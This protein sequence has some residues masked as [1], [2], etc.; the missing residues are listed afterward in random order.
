M[1]YA[2]KEGDVD[3]EK[4]VRLYP[5]C[6]VELDGDAAEMS[7]EWA[8]LNEEKVNVLRYVLVFDLTPPSQEQKVKT[9]LSYETREELIS[10]MQKVSEALNE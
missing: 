5:A 1:I 4:L 9:T 8:E 7:L 3:L 10:E 6:V 2:T